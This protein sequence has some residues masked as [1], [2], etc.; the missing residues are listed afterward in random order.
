MISD[1]MT[2]GAVA[3]KVRA[4][5]GTRLRTD[6]YQHLASL[7]SVGEVASVL[8]S[9]PFW[10]EALDTPDAGVLSRE[11]IEFL[12]KRHY[13]KEYLKLFH[14]LKRDEKVILK[15]PVLQAESEQI[16]KFMR[17]AIEDRPEDYIFDMP[18]FFSQHSKIRYDLLSSAV[19]YDD[20]LV[21]VHNTDFFGAL[22]EIRPADGDFPPYLMVES[23]MRRYYFRALYGILGK[24]RGKTRGLLMESIGIQADWYNIITLDRIHTSYPSLIPNAYQYLLTIGGHIKPS[25]LLRLCAARDREAFDKALETTWYARF[26][27]EARDQGVSLERCAGLHQLRFFKRHMQAD[28]PTIFAPIAFN[29]LI[30]N[31]LQNLTHVIECVRYGLPPSEA[32]AYLLFTQ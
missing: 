20:M 21:A 18:S 26:I 16:M 17:Y 4:M 6:D 5:Y 29:T 3:T 27:K 14:Y 2:Y 31:E 19:S 23:T 30:D 9:H 15:Y 8:R 25:A 13:L 12:M 1:L 11:R 10:G 28:I 22:A 32:E 7:Q 24:R